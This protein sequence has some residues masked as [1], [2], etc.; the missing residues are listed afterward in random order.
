MRSGVAPADVF[1]TLLGEF[2]GSRGAAD[3]R[4]PILAAQGFY[5]MRLLFEHGGGGAEFEFYSLSDNSSNAVHQLVNDS[6][7]SIK[8]YYSAGFYSPC[9]GAVCP[10]I[11]RSG[12]DAFTPLVVQLVDGMTDGKPDTV[13]SVQ[14][15]TNGTLVTGLTPIRANGG[16]TIRLGSPPTPTFASGTNTV[17]VV[18][19]DSNS[20][21][22]TNSWS[23]SLA[24]PSTAALTFGPPVISGNQVTISW[25]GGGTLQESA[26][27]T[28]Q[29]SDWSDVPGVTGESYSVTINS[30]A[31]LFF[32]LRQ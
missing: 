16:T 19:T 15:Y 18:Y 3:T 23:F 20:V 1:G 8:A 4:I 25:T 9:I 13:V 10:P 17:M 24:A 12:L 31:N 14:V 29:A 32:R 11:G 7:N 26:R 21:I 6:T 30:A 28:G 2:E 5:P 27:L 22:Y